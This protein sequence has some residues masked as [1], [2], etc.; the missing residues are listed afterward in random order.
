M[1]CLDIRTYSVIPLNEECG[2]IEW[3]P[4]T[5]GLR[6]IIQKSMDARGI[7][8]YVRIFV[9]SKMDHLTYRMH[10]PN[11]L[12]TNMRKLVRQD[13]LW[14]RRYLHNGYSL[15]KRP[16]ESSREVTKAPR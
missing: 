1:F 6:F 4:N 5:I 7:N 12:R 15:S 10:S 14:L 2:L 8:L 13:R 9:G 16:G 11:K 3:V